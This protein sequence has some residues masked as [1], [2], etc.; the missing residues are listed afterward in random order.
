[1]AL[2]IL[3]YPDPRLRQVSRPVESITDVHRKLAE[4][5][6]KTMYL[7]EGIGLA[8]PQV[9]HFERLVVIDITGPEVREG[10]MVLVNPA[11]TPIPEAGKCESEEGCLSVPEYRSKVKRHAR[12]R[13]Q[14]TDLDGNPVDFEAEGLLA[15]CVQHELDHLDGKLFIDHISRLKRSLFEGRVR[16]KMREE[17]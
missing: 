6:T 5:M 1:M 10:L 4:A 3:H 17:A 9:G 11:I 16:K 15:V 12:V 2:P 14:A 7:A 8:A 13:V